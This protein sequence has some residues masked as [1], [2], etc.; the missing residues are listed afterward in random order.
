VSS[1]RVSR[2]AIHPRRRASPGAIDQQV[3]RFG[4]NA[5]AGSRLRQ[6]QRLCPPAE[7]GVVGNSQVRPRRPM[8]EPIKPSVRRRARWNTALSI[9]SVRIAGGEYQACPPRVSGARL[10]RRDS[11]V[12]EPYRQAP[13]LPQTRVIRRP[14]HHLALLL[15][16]VVA[17]RRVGLE[18]HGGVPDQNRGCRPI[19][20]DPTAPTADPCNNAASAA[21]RPEQ[22]GREF[23][24]TDATVRAD[25][26]ALQVAAAGATVSFHP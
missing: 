5:A 9:S 23:P 25:H 7:S 10:A 17:T 13:A 19:P 22:P 12:G 26:E 3:H 6:V 21:Q 11:L 24:P 8:I 18:R 14:F 15:L 4:A 20:A 2:P 1:C 16:D